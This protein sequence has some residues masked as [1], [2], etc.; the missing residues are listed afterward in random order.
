MQSTLARPWHHVCRGLRYGSKGSSQ[1]DAT[2][3]D[4]QGVMVDAVRV[5]HRDGAT[6]QHSE[7]GATL[8]CGK[9]RVLLLVHVDTVPKHTLPRSPQVECRFNISDF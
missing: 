6:L 2:I 4:A 8:V 3:E 7:P 5:A 1:V 9:E